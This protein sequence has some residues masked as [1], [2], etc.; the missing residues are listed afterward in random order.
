MEL[1]TH[2]HLVL[3]L[4]KEVKERARLY[5]YTILDL[6]LLIYDKKLPF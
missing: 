3:R 4:K 1:T 5:L 6:S 2:F